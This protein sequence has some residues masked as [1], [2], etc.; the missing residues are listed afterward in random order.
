VSDLEP[1]DAWKENKKQ[2]IEKRLGGRLQ[3][4]RERREARIQ[5]L[6]LE[7]N[8]PGKKTQEKQIL[9][10]YRDDKE[11]L[12]ALAQKAFTEALMSEREIRRLS[13]GAAVEPT[14]L[15]R[16][17]KARNNSKGFIFPIYLV[18]G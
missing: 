5:A 16:T 2:E 7:R 10:D 6:A 12:M 9:E 3:A 4:A 18:A 13:A 8:S 15:A 17:Q 14:I 1:D 11:V